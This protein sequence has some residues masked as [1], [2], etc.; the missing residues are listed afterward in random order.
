MLTTSIKTMAKVDF[1]IVHDKG[2]VTIVRNKTAGQRHAE[3]KSKS[4]RVQCFD[5]KQID[6]IFR[7]QELQSAK[8]EPTKGTSIFRHFKF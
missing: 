3:I 2:E 1:S 8:T 5:S 6:R 7:Y 4:I